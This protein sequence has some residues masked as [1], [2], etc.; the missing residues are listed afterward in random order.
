M[1]LPLLPGHLVGRLAGGERE[2]GH[3][4]APASKKLRPLNP[5]PSGYRWG[6][7]P[8]VSETSETPLCVPRGQLWACAMPCP[9]V[10]ATVCCVPARRGKFGHRRSIQCAQPFLSSLWH[11]CCIPRFVIQCD[12][13]VF[14]APPR[15]LWVLGS[16]WPTVPGVED[17]P[18]IGNTSA[19]ESAPSV[20]GDGSP[21]VLPPDF[22]PRFPSSQRRDLKSWSYHWVVSLPKQHLLPGPLEQLSAGQ[23]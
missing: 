15:C 11:V 2:S 19:P 10:I 4:I 13:D 9:A 5:V 6:Q 21:S 8:M 14:A 16:A 12:T 23:L 1:P 3:L 22:Q 7:G 17:G 20:G 18:A